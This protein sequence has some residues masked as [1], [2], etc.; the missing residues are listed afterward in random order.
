[1]KIRKCVGN[2][3]VNLC[4]CLADLKKLNEP[5]MDGDDTLGSSKGS[6]SIGS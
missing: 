2:K 1:M 5:L 6:L 3:L 4:E